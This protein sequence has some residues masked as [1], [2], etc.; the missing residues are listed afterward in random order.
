MPFAVAGEPTGIVEP[1]AGSIAAPEDA[2]LG[3]VE[4]L[5]ELVEPGL[6]CDA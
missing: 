6:V 2:W 3:A 5:V 4:P 1:A